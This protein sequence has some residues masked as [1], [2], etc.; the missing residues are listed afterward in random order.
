MSGL[1]HDLPKRCSRTTCNLRE[2][3]GPKSRNLDAPR[4]PNCTKMTSLS[5]PFRGRRVLP[6]STRLLAGGANDEC[7]SSFLARNDDGDNAVADHPRLDSSEH[8]GG[9]I[10]DLKT[11]PL[12]A[13]AAV[14]RRTG[15]SA[16]L[17][18]RSGCPRAHRI[19][20]E[21]CSRCGPATVTMRPSAR[22]RPGGR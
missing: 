15:T 6:P 2:R 16:G 3:L 13:V 11:T 17:M 7:H 4:V 8:L 12:A 10:R 1:R 5:E 14:G 21:A 18:L 19:F 22:Y 20:D 9:R